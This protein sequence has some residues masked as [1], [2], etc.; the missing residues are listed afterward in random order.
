MENFDEI[1][2]S[3]I[4]KFDEMLTTSLETFESTGK[5]SS[6]EIGKD[7]GKIINDKFKDMRKSHTS[8]KKKKSSDIKSDSDSKEKESKKDDGEVK[9]KKPRKSKKDDGEVKEKKPRKPSIWN[10]YMKKKM[11]E[12]KIENEKNGVTKNPKEMLADIA[13][14][15]KD[16]KATFKVE[17]E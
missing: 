10:I 9:E 16:D 1:K 14:L 5:F 15:W 13:L 12:Y 6:S 17:D 4:K 2:A 11:A 8:A 7:I 3:I